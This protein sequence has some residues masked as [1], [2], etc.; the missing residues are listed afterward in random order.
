MLTPLGKGRDRAL[1]IARDLIEIAEAHVERAREEVEAAFR[2]VPVS[3]REVKLRDGLVALLEDALVF[4]AGSDLDAVELR[5]ALFARATTWRREARFDRAALLEE[6]A[7]E[8]GLDRETLE[9]SLYA[10]LRGAARLRAPERGALVPGGASALVDRYDLAQAQAALVRATRVLVAIGGRSPIALRALFRKLK[11][12]R[13]LFS[14][15]RRGEAIA[16]EIDGPSS[17]FESTTRYG[18][19]LAL[20]LPSLLAC[21]PERLRAELSW[22]KERTPL[23]LV[24]EPPSPLLRAWPEALDEERALSDDALALLER[25]RAKAG[26]LEVQIADAILDVPGLGL[27][28]PDLTLRD[29]A[30]GRRAHVEV[31]GH[32]SR[33][34]VWRRVELAERGLVEPVLFCVSERLRVS[35]AVLSERT[36]AGLYVYKGVISAGLVLARVEALLEAAATG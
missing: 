16:L 6:F 35:E 34:A 7:R 5:D 12:H 14:I 17:L 26:R 11:F 32:W 20:A 13:L 30:S 15:E 10:D 21:R 25:L 8:R 3:S 33:E 1:A 4:E 18:L 27:V 24:I 9:A 31:L 23:E 36:H 29:P 2:A 28:V 22:G 19:A